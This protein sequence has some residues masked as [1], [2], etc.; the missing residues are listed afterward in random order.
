MVRCRVLLPSPWH[1]CRR[2]IRA[3]GVPWPQAVRGAGSEGPTRPKSLSYG[4]DHPYTQTYM[5]ALHKSR[6]GSS[7]EALVDYQRAL[8]MALEDGGPQCL[9]HATVMIDMAR[10]HATMG[11]PGLAVECAGKGL[12]VFERYWGRGSRIYAEAAYDLARYYALF[13][14]PRDALD[15]L[16]ECRA[17]Y[18][19]HLGPDHP[20][21]AQLLRTIQILERRTGG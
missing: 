19:R 18:L 1:A 20:K 15:M 7:A 3:C 4:L 6:S 14:K 8:D 17:A 2:S 21:T 5:R 10:V 13:G 11:N 9:E 16:Y 12:P